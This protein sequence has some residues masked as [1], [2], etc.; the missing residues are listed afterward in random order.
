MIEREI[1]GFHQDED[2][3]WV[4]DLICGHTVHVRHN[5]PWQERPWVLTAE[6]RARF[7]G[8]TFNCGRCY[9]EQQGPA[10]NAGSA[11]NV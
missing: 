8:R 4:A 7:L 3:H 10:E 11:E 5:P 9:E 1:V 6:G 2:G